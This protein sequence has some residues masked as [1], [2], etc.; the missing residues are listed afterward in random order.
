MTDTPLRNLLSRAERHGEVEGLDVPYRC[1]HEAEIE[2]L[3]AVLRRIADSSKC[4]QGA[5]VWWRRSVA[6]KRAE[7][8][9]C[10]CLDVSLHGSD[11]ECRCCRRD[12]EAGS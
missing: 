9:A 11:P 12:T 4:E 6:G 8:E 2:R 1:G 5:C 3:R 7:D 10:F